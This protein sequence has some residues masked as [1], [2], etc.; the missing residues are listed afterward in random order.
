MKIADIDFPDPLLDAL[1]DG[2]LVIFAGAGVSMGKPSCLPDFVGLADRIAAGTGQT[3]QNVEDAEGAEPVDRFLGRLQLAGAD[4]HARAAQALSRGGGSSRRSCIGIFC[5][6][7]PAPDRFAWSPPTSIGCSSRHQRMSW[8]PAPRCSE[9]PR[10]LW[11]TISTG[12][13]TFM[14]R[15]AILAEWSSRT[16]ILGA[17]I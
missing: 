15:L 11:G 4:V 16:G 13:S 9:R 8:I 2:K 7:L 3:R 1:R 12:L 10:C 14:A 5:D 17:P 6:F